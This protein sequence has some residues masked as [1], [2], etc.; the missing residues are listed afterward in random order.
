MSLGAGVHSISLHVS[1]CE[2]ARISDLASGFYSTSRFLVEELP[3]P[4]VDLNS[5]ITF[6]PS[7]NYVP[8]WHQCSVPG[9]NY[10]DDNGTINA[11]ECVFTKKGSDTDIVVS[12]DGSVRVLHCE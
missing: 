11:T 12:W 1:N 4:G 3:P 8:I 10:A 5:R 6:N 2:N 7:Y 9:L